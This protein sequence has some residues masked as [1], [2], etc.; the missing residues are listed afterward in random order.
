VFQQT[1]HVRRGSYLLD[2]HFRVDVAV[3]QKSWCK[4]SW[5][6]GMH[7]C[8]TMATISFNVNRLWHLISLYTFL[9]IVQRASSRTCSMW[10]LKKTE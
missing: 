6:R 10:Y 1:S 2:Y 5:L 3:I 7:F 8:D 4:L 9:P